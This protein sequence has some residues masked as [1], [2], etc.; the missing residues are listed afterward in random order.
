MIPK[1][2]SIDSTKPCESD[3]QS[4][5]PAGFSRAAF[6]HLLSLLRRGFY[7]DLAQV[8]VLIR[9]MHLNESFL[10]YLPSDLQARLQKCFDEIRRDEEF[11]AING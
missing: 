3:Q 1:Q 8:V 7:R 6:A 5:P 9:A 4:D 2:S 10:Q 11:Y